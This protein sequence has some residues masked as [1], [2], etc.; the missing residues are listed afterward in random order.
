MPLN[1]NSIMTVLAEK[2]YKDHNAKNNGQET[3]ITYTTIPHNTRN[4][5]RKPEIFIYQIAFIM[6]EQTLCV[7]S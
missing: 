5:S 7:C 4:K 3:T 1:S 2:Q 6:Q